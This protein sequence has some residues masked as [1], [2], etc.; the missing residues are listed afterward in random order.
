MNHCLAAAATSRSANVLALLSSPIF[1]NYKLT[2]GNSHLLKKKK[3]GLE[4]TCRSGGQC[5]INRQPQ[6][7]SLTFL[8]WL[9]HCQVCK[10]IILDF[11]NITCKMFAIEIFN[12]DLKLK[13]WKCAQIKLILIWGYLHPNRVDGINSTFLCSLPVFKGSK[14]IGQLADQLVHD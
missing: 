5:W 12:L 4:N 10:N 9:Q 7:L 1:Y 2:L 14:V 6:I 8:S 3:K 11:Q 13:W